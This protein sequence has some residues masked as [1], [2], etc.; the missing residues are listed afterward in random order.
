MNPAVLTCHHCHTPLVM[1]GASVACHCGARQ[2]IV[3]NGIYRDCALRGGSH[4]EMRVRDPQ[5]STYL[6]HSKFP[7]QLARFH[8]WLRQATGVVQYVAP[9]VLTEDASKVALDLGCSAGPYTSLLQTAG[10]KVIALDISSMP[11]QLNAQSCRQHTNAGSTVFVQADLNAVD[12][13][14]QSVDVLVM[15]DFLQH[16]GSRVL[17]ERLLR[18]A[19]AALRPGGLFCLSFFNMNIKNY[20]NGDIHGDF[21]QGSIP[22]ERLSVRNVLSFFPADIE[23]ELRCPMNIFHGASLDAACAKLPGA[24]FLARMAWI[25]GRKRTSS[26]RSAGVNQ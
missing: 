4:S 23:V 12:I 19:F 7:T 8:H 14:P 6:Q 10:F 17:R 1:Q 24:F 25:T 26:A 3:D 16:L 2:F 9:S 13:R 21:A 15:A 20:L 5:A 22:Y 11:L 18:Q